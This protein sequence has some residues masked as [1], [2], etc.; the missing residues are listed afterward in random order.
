MSEAK[1]ILDAHVEFE[2]ARW[3]GESRDEQLTEE[4]AAAFAWLKTV[5]LN[6]LFTSAEIVEWCTRYSQEFEVT[7]QLLAMIGSAA[8]SAYVAAS[9]DDTRIGDLIPEAS[10]DQVASAVLDMQELREMI[11]TQDDQ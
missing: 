6:Q 8:R 9:K 3:T 4:V 5:R 10:Y 2:L 11:T 7:D 1:K